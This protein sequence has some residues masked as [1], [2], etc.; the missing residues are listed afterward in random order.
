MNRRLDSESIK[1]MIIGGL[2]AHLWGAKREIADIDIQ[3]Q[4]KDFKKVHISFGNIQKN[5]QKL[6]CSQEN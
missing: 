5:C 2:A 6:L 4:A 3:V 1:F